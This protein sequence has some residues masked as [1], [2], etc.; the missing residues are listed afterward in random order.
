MNL[1]AFAIAILAILMALIGFVRPDVLV[2]LGRYSFSPIGLYVVAMIRLAVGLIFFL[3]AR[4]SRAPRTLRIIGVLI[5]VVGVALAWLTV[6]RGDALREW[7]DLRG[8]GFVRVAAMFV[9]GLGT[10][11]AYAT[12][13]RRR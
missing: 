12:A 10:F 1:L 8:L 6:E 3:G 4:R 11:I 5:C 2:S 9:L 7:W 13:P